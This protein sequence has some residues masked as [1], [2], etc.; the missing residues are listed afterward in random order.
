VV[1]PN[2]LRDTTQAASK[3]PAYST[4]SVRV[5]DPGKIQV[6]ED[7]IKKMGFNTFSMLD[8]TRSLRTLLRRVGSLPGNLRKPRIGGG[9]DW[10]REYVGNG[11]SGTSPG[12]WHH[13]GNWR[14]R[15]RCEETFLRGRRV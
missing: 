2:A 13:E 5:K 1:Q 3:V 9:F 12:D 15:C 14:F 8:A 11:D 10:Y 7:A 6:V 4:V